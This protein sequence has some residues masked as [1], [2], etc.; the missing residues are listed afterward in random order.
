M[1]YFTPNSALLAPLPSDYEYYTKIGVVINGVWYTLTRNDNIATPTF[2]T[3]GIQELSSTSPLTVSELCNRWGYFNIV[4]HWRSGQYIGE[5]YFLGGG[6]NA[7]GY[8]TIDEKNNQIVL[9]NVPV[10]QF[11]ME[12]VS[13]GSDGG[14]TLISQSAVEPIRQYVHWQLKEH[15]YIDKMNIG[16]KQRAEYNF[17][18]AF[19]RYKMIVTTPT[20]QEYVDTMYNSFMSTVKGVAV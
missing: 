15:T 20:I 8:F 11:C 13:N 9:R 16:E 17:E 5:A 3:C 10:T 14:A 18:K 19:Q 2:N 12:Y 1:H 7:L 4:P 6:W